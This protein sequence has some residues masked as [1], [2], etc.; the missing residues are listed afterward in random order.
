[1]KITLKTS[2]LATLIMCNGWMTQPASSHT[3]EECLVDPVGQEATHHANCINLAN[4]TGD[5]KL[6]FQLAIAYL[7]GTGVPEDRA[8]AAVW[9]R[10]AASQGLADAQYIL[11][12]MH[13]FGD[14][15]PQDYAK[16]A[17]WYRK[18]ALQGDSAA[19][20]LLARM[21]Y[22][23]DGVPQDY[24]TA[25]MWV[26]MAAAS[27]DQIPKDLRDEILQQLTPEQVTEG[28]KMTR[29]WL[30]AYPPRN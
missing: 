18:V 10:K 26:N 3:L 1:M 29:G 9:L 27:G 5:K 15:V 22:D 24:I 17:E 16:A 20:Y 19:Q 25:Y 8:K 23:G 7:S 30:A 11:A 14:G 21:H 2:V 6:Q 4:K 13:Y 28:Q 12:R